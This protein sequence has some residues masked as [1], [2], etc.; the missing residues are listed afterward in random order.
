MTCLG[1]TIGQAP[2]LPARETREGDVPHSLASIDKAKKLIDY[3]PKV[4]LD[5]GLAKT[6][7]WFVSNYNKIY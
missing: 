4:F 3:N 6:F 2:D 5:E 1:S 7:E